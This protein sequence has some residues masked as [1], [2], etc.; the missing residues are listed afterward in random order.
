MP[1]MFKK[2]DVV[3]GFDKNFTVASTDGPYVHG[4]G[5]YH[6]K[7]VKFVS[8]PEI[9]SFLQAGKTIDAIKAWRTITGDG[10]KEAKDAV[11][12]L[13]VSVPKPKFG[14]GDVVYNRHSDHTISGVKTHYRDDNTSYHGPLAYDYTDG[15]WDM[16]SYLTLVRRAESGQTL[17]DILGKALAAKNAKFKVGDRVYSND[18]PNGIGTV[19]EI[20]ERYIKV[21]FLPWGV[22][23]WCDSELTLA[24]TPT[25]TIV[26]RYDE[27]KGYRPN[28]KPVVHNTLA[29]ATKEA[30]RLAKA[31][32]GVKFA[33]FTLAT[34][35]VATAPTVTTVSV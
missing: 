30:E 27:G 32:P 33:T 28:D 7:N 15:G 9:I 1:N 14:P 19:T 34:T 6:Y 2:G 20:S 3:R 5:C 24:V 17:G 4:D 25:P 8:N 16:E 11:E 22:S 29:E 10:L 13:A 31:N 23:S 18:D 21:N 35:S 12:A 26:V